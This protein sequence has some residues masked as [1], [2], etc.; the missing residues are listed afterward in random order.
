VAGE[1]TRVVVT[2]FDVGGGDCPFT[3]PVVEITTVAARVSAGTLQARFPVTYTFLAPLSP[4]R[5]APSV[6][7]LC[8]DAIGVPTGYCVGPPLEDDL[9]QYWC[10]AQDDD[11]D[12]LSLTLSFR[13]K[14]GCETADHCWTKSRSFAPRPVPSPVRLDFDN[15]RF[16]EGTGREVTCR[17]VDSLDRGAEK[18][19]CLGRE[20]R[21]MPGPC[22]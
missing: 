8:W 9:M 17:V 15:R 5:T 21:S 19:V 22:P 14:S 16:P 4:T 18:T 13:T 10:V 2:S 20:R 11:G 7:E 1:T 6:T 3:N 12:A